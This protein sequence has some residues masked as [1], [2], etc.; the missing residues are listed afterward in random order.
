MILI[1]LCMIIFVIGL[2]S[3]T[4]TEKPDIDSVD[5]LITSAKYK[6]ALEILRRGQLMPGLNPA[7]KLRIKTRVEKV[8]RLLFFEKLNHH[9]TVNNWE[10][11][12][13][14]AD[15]LKYKITLL[16]E[17]SKDP[18]YFDYYHLKSKTDSAL[19]GLEAWQISLEKANQ[20]YTPEYQ[21]VQEIY[22]KLAFYHARRGEFV[23]AREMMDK[24]MRKMNL[25]VMDSALSK[26]YQL[27]MDGKF[28]EACAELKDLKNINLD[29]HWQSARKFLNFYADSLT[30]EDR[31]KLW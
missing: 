26:V 2:F 23:K 30:L 11:A 9:I 7:E 4:C 19:S 13:K 22:E 28:T 3:I 17:K 12:G 27:Y 14:H 6:Q 5:S 25:S 31:Y 21:Q 29:A 10:A 1:R 20:Y 24:S 16:P 15:T 18:Y 8:Q